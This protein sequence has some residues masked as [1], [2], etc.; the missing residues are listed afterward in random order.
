LLDYYEAFRHRLTF[1]RDYTAFLWG[2]HADGGFWE[3]YLLAQLW[4]TPIPTLL[5][6]A[7]SLWLI[8]RCG[9][10]DR[11]RW[12]F[13]L[14]PILTFHVT[15]SLWG[16][17]V[18]VRHV[19]PVYPFVF[20]CCGAVASRVG[21]ARLRHRIVFALLC[22][23]Y[24]AGTV[25]AYPHF[26][27]Y[28][29]ELAGG[30]RGGI[31]YLGD[32]NIEWGQDLYALK[33]R[34]EASRPEQL[35]VAV[36]GKL[37]PEDYGISSQ[38]I[39]LRDIVW[40]RENVT[41]FVGAQHLQ[42]EPYLPGLRFRWLE[43]YEP[44][45]RIGWSIYEYRFSTDEADRQ[46]PDVFLL[47]EE[48][49]YGDAIDDLARIVELTPPLTEGWQLLAEALHARG[50]WRQSRGE[51]ESALSDYSKAVRLPESLPAYRDELRSVISDLRRLVTAAGSAVDC[52][53]GPVLLQ[54]HDEP[55]GLKA[56]Y[57]CL[58][59]DPQ[60]LAAHAA[61]AEVY[62]NWGLADLAASEWKE[63]LRIDREHEAARR[64]LERLSAERKSS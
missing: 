56:L 57:G 38:T 2:E 23:W 18:G 3:Y 9:H 59:L 28:F 7:A 26:L 54:A 20:L 33:D 49:W 25:R 24:V 60:R 45:R 36:A 41:Y 17:D 61:L 11:L 64:A 4:K 43:R 30:P 46:N 32:S 39:G 12:P 16:V 62:E 48:R 8:E 31:H 6:F 15:A 13:L 27:P 55:G 19:L 5:F 50:K 22:I 52:E 37:Q 35:R 42:H 63:C 21:E 10:D 40:P 51:I 53:L 34:I 44:I 14:L 29:N 47:D 1:D 58:Q